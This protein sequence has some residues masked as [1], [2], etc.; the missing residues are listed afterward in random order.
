MIFG[1]AEAQLIQLP[2]RYVSPVLPRTRATKVGKI[3]GESFPPCGPN[4]YHPH[5]R[6]AMRCR[7]L[8][9]SPGIRPASRQKDGEIDNI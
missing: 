6:S 4:T 9:L 3:R 7:H 1:D 5:W 8:R 2:P